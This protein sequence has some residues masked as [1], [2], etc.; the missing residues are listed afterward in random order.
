MAAAA[1]GCS[2][3]WGWKGDSIQLGGWE[4]EQSVM[5]AGVRGEGKEAK[6]HE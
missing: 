6:Q 4:E 2:G 5:A 3:K 1:R